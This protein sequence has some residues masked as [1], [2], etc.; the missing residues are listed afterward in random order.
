MTTVS[1]I[2]PAGDHLVLAFAAGADVRRAQLAS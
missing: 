2:T 1:R